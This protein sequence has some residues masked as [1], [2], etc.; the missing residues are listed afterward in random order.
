M[1]E[2]FP[3]NKKTLLLKKGFQDGNND[4]FMSL[5]V[6]GSN[7][8]IKIHFENKTSQFHLT[9]QNHT[10]SF[11]ILTDTT[12]NQMQET[13]QNEK[14]P[15]KKKR[16][17][18]RKTVSK[19]TKPTKR[20]KRGSGGFDMYRPLEVLCAEDPKKIL[21]WNLNKILKKNI[22]NV[23][24]DKNIVAHMQ[25]ISLFIGVPIE[26]LRVRDMVVAH[27]SD[28]FKPKTPYI[29]IKKEDGKIKCVGP[30]MIKI[31]NNLFINLYDLVK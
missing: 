9:F 17:R 13:E 11:G 31:M 4:L 3:V 7:D 27:K 26:K 15:T 20:R 12:I 2:I 21:N 10:Q 6:E 8:E 1:T 29:K 23:S 19:T 28:I 25:E 18:P 5:N 22:A 16:G 30:R 24:S 14:V